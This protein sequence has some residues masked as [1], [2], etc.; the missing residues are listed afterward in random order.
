[1]TTRVR[2]LNSSIS[3][4]RR[5]ARQRGATLHGAWPLLLHDEQIVGHEA[6]LAA[7][8]GRHLADGLD[9]VQP[10]IFLVRGLEGGR[11]DEIHVGGGEND[12]LP[13]PLEILAGDA[14]DP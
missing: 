4:S 13:H 11:R 1:M 12:A 3:C 2:W 8:H 5:T 10:G 7:L 9:M 6:A 14:D